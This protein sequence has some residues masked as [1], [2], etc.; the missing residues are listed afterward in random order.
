MP[1]PAFC[2][3]ASASAIAAR[4]AVSVRRGTRAVSAA[5]SCCSALIEQ[6]RHFARAGVLRRCARTACWLAASFAAR[7]RAIAAVERVV[8]RQAIVAL[9]DRVLC[10]LERLDGRLVLL[11]GV[12]IGSGGSR[13]VDRALGLIHFAARR[14]GAGQC[15]RNTNREVQCTERDP[16]DDA[17]S[18]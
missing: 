9:R 15:E 3:D 4:A 12:T 13:G 2:K 16:S 1:V 10:A 7:L 11:C 6:R 17:T 8:Q 18:A 14:R 5:P